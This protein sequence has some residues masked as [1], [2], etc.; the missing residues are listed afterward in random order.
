[1]D[2]AKASQAL[3]GLS[4]LNLGTDPVVTL[5]TA[6]AP[7]KSQRILGKNSASIQDI[8][9]FR[10]IPYGI[11]PGRWQHSILRR[12][13]PSDLFDATKNGPRCPQPDWLNNTFIFQS[14]L[15]FPTDVGESEFDCLNLFVVRPSA[16]ALDRL[17]LD[18]HNTKLPVFVWIHG[19]G[20]GFGAST[21]PPWDPARLVARSLE[22]KKPI[23][24][25]ALNYRLNCFGFLASPEII[26]AQQADAALRGGNFGLGDQRVAL[27]WVSE[28]IIHFGGDPTKITI[29]GQ[30]AGG[31][32]VHAQVIN[33]IFGMGKPLFR[34]AAIQSGA[35][36]TLGPIPLE[37]AAANLDLLSEKLGLTESSASERV[38]S[39]LKTPTAEL[40][41]AS[42]AL[43]WWVFPLV[44]DNLTIKP[45]RIGR[46]AL[47]LGQTK[48]EHV[49]DNGRDIA[50]IDV[51]VGD[52]DTEGMLWYDQAQHFADYAKLEALF[53]S[54]IHQS[55]VEEAFQ[56]YDIKTSSTVDEIRD[57]VMSM[58]TDNEFGIPVQL[59]REELSSTSTKPSSEVLPTRT[60][61]FR[62]RCGNPWPG[63]FY[64]MAQHCID[65]LYLFDC[66]HE[67]LAKADAE[68]LNDGELGHVA[69]VHH[70][71]RFW[72][73]FIADDNKGLAHPENQAMMF[74][75]D[76]SV[77][78]DDMESDAEWTRRKTRFDFVLKN[79]E[80]L[81]PV[82]R[83]MMGME[84][85]T[86]WDHKP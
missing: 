37:K 80:V 21:D 52:A 79:K 8:E 75:Q 81:E 85:A 67:S 31:S 78:L 61:S 83:H 54:R 7:G 22:F 74:R 56:A 82:V 15:D 29:G 69:L 51:L 23:I 59:A 86:T 53:K 6:D 11:V 76:R 24:S 71:Q 49:N 47:S 44:D 73:D 35:V 41:K 2:H 34:R 39:L 70:T 33:A 28:N 18:G 27:E 17:G 43:G 62:F 32:S 50:G 20:Y 12:S 40:L 10:G 46:W 19:G 5:P 14:H 42:E 38:Q 63:P 26:A 13:L 48:A 16:E 55:L 77:G 36:G 64:K 60:Q 72:I 9:E 66:F 84:V 1:M 68:V 45:S 65:L 4:V 57:G 3:N 58:I 25:V 30:S